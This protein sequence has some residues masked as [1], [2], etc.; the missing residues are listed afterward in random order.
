MTNE[1]TQESRTRRKWRRRGQLLRARQQQ[2]PPEPL[3]APSR[4]DWWRAAPVLAVAFLGLAAVAFGLLTLGEGNSEVADSVEWAT[5]KAA[6]AFSVAIATV[7]AGLGVL[8][9]RR[10]YGS[11]VDDAP[12][13]IGGTR[14]STAAR[15][16]EPLQLRPVIGWKTLGGYA[17][18]AL[19][20][21]AG[22]FV[23]LYFAVPIPESRSW[24]R[25]LDIGW[26]T[27]GVAFAI[28][29][30][31]VP[32]LVL[33]WLLQRHLTAEAAQASPLSTKDL[34][35][36]WEVLNSIVLAFAVFVVLALVPTGALR[37]AYFAGS[38]DP[39]ADKNGPEFPSSQVLLYGAFFAVLLSAIALPMVSAWRSAARKRLAHGY[40]LEKDPPD[41]NAKE[42]LDRAEALLHLDVGV[43]RSPITALTVFTPLVTAA[44]A[45]YL[46]DL[47]S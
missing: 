31:A 25:S 7:S 23:F 47:A 39:A 41:A 9:V 24:P 22:V 15:L 34:R 17:A 13:A 2:P 35:R 42:G 44:L 20:L 21:T 4:A 36:L 10:A 43:L 45:A 8:T 5:W 29:L 18:V 26:R 27:S 19:A 16:G 1:D 30:A 6:A 37:A 38:K 3:P 28:G 33:V 14:S 46:P 40:P 32:W 12:H 11:A